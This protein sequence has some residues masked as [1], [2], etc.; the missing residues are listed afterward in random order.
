MLTTKELLKGYGDERENAPNQERVMQIWEELH[1]LTAR[2][3][4]VEV[5]HVKAHC[6]KKEKKVM[7]HFEKFVTEGNEKA[8]DLAKG[9]WQKREQRQRSRSEKRCT[10]PCSTQPGFTV[11]WRNGKIVKNL[12]PSQKKSGSSWI[13]KI[14]TKH[15]NGVVRGNQQVSVHEVWKKAA[16]T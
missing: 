7:S 16:N 10:Q 15:R 9:L 4:T 1:S 12:R 6:T 14:R 8:D 11:W 3:T 13:S 5:G 2:N